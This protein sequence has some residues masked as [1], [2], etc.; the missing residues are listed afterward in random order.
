M[1]IAQVAISALI[2]QPGSVPK[3][4]NFQDFGILRRAEF[5]ARCI[6]SDMPHLG[7]VSE[8][9]L[10]ALSCFTIIFNRVKQCRSSLVLRREAPSF[11]TS[12]SICDGLKK[13]IKG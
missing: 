9:L 4:L 7:W 3:P 1:I 11:G 13:L 6:I 8:C 2:H 12:L 10:Q 5:C